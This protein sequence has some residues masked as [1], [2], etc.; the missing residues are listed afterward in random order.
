MGNALSRREVEEKLIKKAMEDPAFY[1]QLKDNP[2]EILSK[3]L[4]INLPD[5][6]TV[7]V[8]QETSRDI[9]LVIPTDELG[10]QELDSVSGG[11]DTCW[12]YSGS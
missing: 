7:T 3:E 11:G 10:D 2:R 12:T 9:H 5:D 8:H 4:G 1:G 6:V